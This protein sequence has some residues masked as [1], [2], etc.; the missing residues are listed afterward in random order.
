M[1]KLIIGLLICLMLS[2]IIIIPILGFNVGI[3]YSEN[4]QIDIPIKKEVNVQEI[5]KIADEVFGKG[6]A[7]AQIIELY[8]DSVEITVK[9][10]TSEQIEELNTKIN[11]K[12][13]IENIVSEDVSVIKNANTKLR[14]LITPYLLPIFV[15][16]I[17]I[18]IYNIIRFHKLGI[19]KV[20]YKTVMY[21]IA[22]QAI[23]FS[24]YAVTRLPINNITPILSLIIYIMSAYI[25]SYKLLKENSAKI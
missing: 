8:N 2:A 12:Y 17:I 4:T 7:I 19:W 3:K 9:E 20:L 6:K 14:D 18:V 11:E 5:Q 24:L 25:N 21:I 13:E 15:S 1:K 10:A 16:A 23:L 22:P